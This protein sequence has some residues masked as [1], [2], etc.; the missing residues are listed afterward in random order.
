MSFEVLWERS[1]S[2]N[3]PGITVGISLYCYP[4]YVLSCLDSVYAQTLATF[5]LVVVDDASPDSSPQRALDWLKNKGDR[6]RRA[7]LVRHL[8]NQGLGPTRNRFFLLAQTPWVFVLDADNLLL[9]RCLERHWEV[10]EL[11]GADVVYGLIATFGEKF[12]LRSAVEWD[13]RLLRQYNSFDAMALVRKESWRQCGGYRALPWGWEDYDL[14]IRFC[15]AR[16][17]AVRIPEILSLYRVH[18]ESMTTHTTAKRLEDLMT[19]LRED[20]PEFFG[21]QEKTP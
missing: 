10:A 2:V 21:S 6:F 11:S 20:Y 4:D 9:P 8:H 16:K 3:P 1:F 19:R 12:E 18:G 15:L 17:K 14:W 7:C 5:D 13:C